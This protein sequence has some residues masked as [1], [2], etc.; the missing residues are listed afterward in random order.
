MREVEAGTEPPLKMEPSSLYQRS[1]SS[2]IESSTD[3]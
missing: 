1:G 2:S 3:R